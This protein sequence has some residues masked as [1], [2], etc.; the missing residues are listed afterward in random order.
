MAALAV[1]N[2][3][4]V[5]QVF[6][7][8]DLFAIFFGL[9]SASL[10]IFVFVYF[11]VLRRDVRRCWRQP[12]CLLR[13]RHRAYEEEEDD[14][15]LETSNLYPN[16][17]GSQKYNFATTAFPSNTISDNLPPPHGYNFDV[18]N[19]HQ[20]QFGQDPQI[21]GGTMQRVVVTR[22]TVAATSKEVTTTLTRKDSDEASSDHLS[23]NNLNHL[24]R[25]YVAPVNSG[26]VSEAD[27]TMLPFGHIPKPT[28]NF[29][30]KMTS[31]LPPHTSSPAGSSL[32]QFLDL[33][34]LVA[35]DSH[36]Q[37][38]GP[39]NLVTVTAANNARDL[40]SRLENGYTESSTIKVGHPCQL[41][42]L[43]TADFP[44]NIGGAQTSLA[45]R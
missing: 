7:L 14:Q 34:P 29:Q 23:V 39:Y 3:T 17:T 31:H 16:Q 18:G 26:C 13:T 21:H 12:I 44:S 28:N 40:D 27:Y 11:C 10:G 33:S 8:E 1:T 36:L 25:G 38:Q 37:N 20:L 5:E 19:S 42:S 9:A 2:P 43:T 30:Q 22:G 45:A 15:L 32:P 24:R 35:P 6:P 4:S 41:A